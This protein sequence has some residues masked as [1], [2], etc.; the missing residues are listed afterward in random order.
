MTEGEGERRVEGGMGVGG[1]GG[2][3]NTQLSV[4]IDRNCQR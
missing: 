4:Q 2:H 3:H 1:G